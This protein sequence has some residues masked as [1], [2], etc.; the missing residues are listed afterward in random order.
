MDRGARWAAAHRVTELDLTV[1][2]HMM[3]EELACTP[4]EAVSISVG[5]LGL[6]STHMMGGCLLYSGPSKSHVTVI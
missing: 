2:L 5:V 3:T 1:L 4:V 6:T